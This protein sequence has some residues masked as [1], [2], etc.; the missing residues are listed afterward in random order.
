MSLIPSASEIASHLLP[1]DFASW[2]PTVTMGFGVRTLTM[3]AAGSYAYA[4]LWPESQLFGPCVVGS[5][6]P[7]EVALTFDDG[8][9]DPDTLN[10]LDVLAKHNVRAT[11]FMIGQFVRQRPDIVRAVAAAGHLIGNH[12]MS[13]PLLLTRRPKVVRQ[14]LRDC[15]A[16]L[17]DV[18]GTPVRWFRP[19]HGSRRPDI[20]RFAREIGLKTVMW[21]AMGYDWKPTTAEAVEQ[22]VLRGFRKN[23][24]RGHSTNALLHDGGQA[25][26]AQDRSHTVIATSRLILYWR[27]YFARQ[28]QTCAFVT[29]EAWA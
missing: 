14:Q 23:Q 2:L 25:D 27:N 26:H 15:N 10:L 7:N 3:L 5:D 19:P 22:H 4:G 11:F 20:L 21:N 9:A 8:P 1:A 24:R 16:A 17:E 12:T 13:H 6:R 29:P 28:N 18:L